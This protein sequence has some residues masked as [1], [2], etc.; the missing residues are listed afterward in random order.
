MTTSAAH[1]VGLLSDRSVLLSLQEIAEDIGTADTGRA[2]LDMDEAESLLAA[3]LTAGGQ[4]PVAVSGLPEERLLSVARGL[5]ARIAADPDTAGPAGVVLADPPA[6][7]QMSVESAVT[8][9]VVLGSLVAWLQTKVD[10]RIKRKEGKSEFEFRLS[11]PSASTPLLRELS[12][13]VARLLGG[14]PPGPP[15][16]A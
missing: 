3:L 4:P 6:D 8:A 12:E 13:A 10:I 16:L 1:T 14:G 7:E 5:L 15:P 9:A 11:K 2:P